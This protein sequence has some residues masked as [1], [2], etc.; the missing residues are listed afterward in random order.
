MCTKHLMTEVTAYLSKV[1]KDHGSV[2]T[3]NRLRARYFHSINKWLE[4]LK[5]SKDFFK[6]PGYYEHTHIS[7]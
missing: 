4:V 5:L 3:A 2:N 6:I 7:L 1:L